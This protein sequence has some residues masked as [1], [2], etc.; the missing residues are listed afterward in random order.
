MSVPGQPCFVFEFAPNT[1]FGSGSQPFYTD[2][3]NRVHSRWTCKRG[4]QYERSQAQA[5]TL[6]ATFRNNDGYL[7]PPNTGSPYSP[8]V[9][10]WRPFRVRAQYPATPNVLLGDQATAGEA[11]PVAP[12]AI[13]ASM[14]ISSVLGT[15]VIAA[16]A[17][18]YQGTQV[19]SV[20]IG[21]SAAAAAA[22]Q[23]NYQPIEAYSPVVPVRT[24][25]W[26]IYARSVTSGATPSCTAVI[27]WYNLAGTLVSS[28]T[29][30]VTAL[31]AGGA[32]AAWTRVSVSGSPPAGAIFAA[33]SLNL[34][35]TTP[36]SAWTLQADALQFESSLPPVTGAPTTWGAP[37]TWYGIWGGATNAL[38]RAY[39]GDGVPDSSGN[40]SVL[41]LTAT[42]VI[43][44]LGQPKL[45]DC[46][47]NTL[48]GYGPD[49]LYPLND[50]AYPVGTTQG[51]NDWTGNR[52]P[53]TIGGVGV[54]VTAGQSATGAPN[55]YSSP[56]Y[57]TNGPV[58][59]LSDQQ[60][61]W[62]TPTTFEDEWYC[63]GV[64]L[65][66]TGPGVAVGPPPNSA[67]TRVVAFQMEGLSTTYPSFESGFNGPPY[68]KCCLWS[69]MGQSPN[70]YPQVSLFGYMP[71]TYPG[72]VTTFGTPYVELLAVNASGTT[73]STQFFTNNSPTRIDTGVW[74]LA[75]VSLS[76]DG[77]TFTVNLGSQATDATYQFT[78]STGGVD[79]RTAST[80]SYTADAVGFWYAPWAPTSTS[81]P[82]GAISSPQQFGMNGQLGPVADFPFA[83][84]T[85]QF[86]DMWTSFQSAYSGDSSGQRAA[87]LL[88]WAG[89]KG[90]ARVDPG[91]VTMGPA[92][93]L[94]SANG[95]WSGPAP[96]TTLQST[97]FLE[98]GMMYSAQD[99]EFEFHGAPWREQ[100]V[101]PYC[102]FGEQLAGWV[103]GDPVLGV[104]GSTT[105]LGGEIPYTQFSPG[106][107]SVEII[108][109]TQ[110]SV[111][112]GTSGAVDIP[113][114][115]VNQTSVNNYF[116][117]TVQQTVNPLVVATAQA[118]ANNLV[119]SDAV[120][121]DRIAAL[122]V[123]PAGLP[124]IWPTVLGLDLDTLVQVMRRP[125]GGY[126]LTELQFI[127]MITVQ[128]DPSKPN[129]VFIYQGTSA[130]VSAP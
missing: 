42:D 87:R 22:L 71:V 5:G 125:L 121:R 67:W 104:L 85:A 119:A 74:M 78:L 10:L 100:Q 95:P 77:H 75:A 2:L 83:I 57:G 65:A 63:G 46:F 66:Q 109:I 1:R 30:T 108:N 116:P 92:G 43:G 51:W 82:P 120:P 76:A 130:G 7:D 126:P 17:T 3:T 84:T 41:Q 128:G 28:S 105:I 47:I 29:G 12:G 107:D 26:S 60:A 40:Y 122:Q 69:C 112:N 61:A 24:Y 53:A 55:T 25:S 123:E 27:G 45:N 81:Y 44:V 62:Y 13:P 56:F 36:G 93:G 80:T 99:G 113:V 68:L 52:P 59:S 79:F 124:Q 90:A 88:G 58:V 96:L 72:G 34:A 4:Q 101:I 23:V 117:Q 33:L 35:G 86:Q 127:E 106:Y 39:R 102:T 11:T 6:T 103:L 70:A 8:G 50:P 18:A 21:A 32:T 48:L 111:S 16:S 37:G 73:V 89:L 14:F 129:A 91:T 38:P 110:L 94:G 19:Y 15:P 114:S 49:F 31:A 115:A 54:N 64:V 118:L 20:P 98:Q 9:D 97:V